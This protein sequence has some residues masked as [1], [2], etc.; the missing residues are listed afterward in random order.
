MPNTKQ[1]KPLRDL[2]AAALQ[3]EP[4]LKLR[5]VVTRVQK[6]AGRKVSPL[7]VAATVRQHAGR[8][9]PWKRAGH[10]VYQLREAS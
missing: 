1:Q 4:Q 10:G 8:K 3:K 7:A 5:D 2:I 6:S 9:G